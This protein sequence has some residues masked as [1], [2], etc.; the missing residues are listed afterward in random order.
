[1]ALPLSGQITMDDIRIELGVSTQSPFGLN[2]ARSGTYVAINSCSTYKPPSTGQ[3]SLS[4][5]YGYNQ[6]Q[7]CGPSYD[8]YYADEYSC[9]P[10]TA[11][12]NNILV[13][14]PAGTGIFYTRY[15]NDISF[16][17]FVYR[18]TGTASYGT[19]LILTTT[20]SGTNCNT[21]CSI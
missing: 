7:S 3:V 19:A 8:F 18:L 4:D 1:M 6:T 13:C 5:W 17:G 21:V 12:G 9:N 2:E 16:D 15:Y 14:F 11:T 20:G 10:C